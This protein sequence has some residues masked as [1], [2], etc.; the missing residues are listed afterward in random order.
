MTIFDL[1]V[2][3]VRP[4]DGFPKRPCLQ[5]WVTLAAGG[6]SGGCFIGGD[7]LDPGAS[8]G[9]KITTVNSRFG[10]YFGCFHPNRRKRSILH[11]VP[12]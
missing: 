3:L 6:E 2:V 8:I 10:E 1:T 4:W 12:F 9:T 5:R 11:L 7:F